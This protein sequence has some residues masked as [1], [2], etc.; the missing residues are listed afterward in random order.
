MNWASRG[1]F[2]DPTWRTGATGTTRTT[3]PFGQP[4]KSL[5]GRPWAFTK[6]SGAA[7]PQVGEQC[8]G[9]NDM[10]QHVFCH[11]VEH[12]KVAFLEANCSWL[13]FFLWRL[14]EHWERQGDVHSPELRMAPSDYFK[15]QC[16]ASADPDEMP[17]KYLVD[18]LGSDRLVFSTDFP[19]SDSKFPHSVETFLE[20]PIPDEDKQ[21]DPLGQLRQRTTASPKGRPSI[22]VRGHHC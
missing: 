15:R 7:L 12:L 19:H 2:S 6:G 13:P 11:P 10:L 20:L 8:S 4:W 3:S 17:V 1:S 9:A 5:G 14:D 22:L 16:Y 21:K 18:Y